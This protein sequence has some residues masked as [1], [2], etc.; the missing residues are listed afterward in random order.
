MIMKK[1]SLIYLLAGAIF[2]GGCKKQLEQ[3]DPESIS[4]GNAF[5]TMEHVQLGLNGV[6]GGYGTYVNDIYKS[7]LVSDEAKIGPDNAGQGALTFRYQYSSDGTTGGDVTAGYGPYYG[8]IDL[9]NRILPRVYEVTGNVSQARR[10]EVRGQL[11]GMRAIAHFSVLQSFAKNYDPAEQLGIAIVLESNPL[12]QTG[13]STMAESVAAIEKDLADAKAL[14]PT[15]SSPANFRDTVLNKVNIAAYQA[16]IAL[17]KRDYASAITFATEVINSNV[18]PLV[19]GATFAGIWTDVE[20]L[21]TSIPQGISETLFRI[22]F[23]TGTNLGGLWTT[24]GN[25]TYISPSDKLVSLYG[26]NDIRRAAYIGDISGGGHYVNKYYVSS[27]GGRVVDL[28][29]IRTA[30]MYLIRAEAYARQASPNIAAGAADLNALRAQRI[31]GYVNETF[32]SASELANAVLE[33]RFKELCF[34]GHRFF[35]LKRNN[36]PV[37]RNASDASPAWQTLPAGSYRFVFPIPQ[38]AMLAN[39]NMVQNEGY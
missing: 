12:G 28:K 23:L 24:N 32:A 10:D 38:N 20:S 29:A 9:A 27:R 26:P 25:L 14:M 21:N 37:Q 17:W 19:T 4:E 7:A 18:K 36:L 6:I 1:N 30:E 2:L 5:Q 34:E 16:R 35:D 13:R 33:E 11:L 3:Y 15:I 8:M 31:T 22:R 39:P